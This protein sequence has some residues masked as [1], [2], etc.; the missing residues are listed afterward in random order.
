MDMHALTETQVVVCSYDIGAILELLGF[1]LI[2]S[3]LR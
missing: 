3:W 1:L 2:S